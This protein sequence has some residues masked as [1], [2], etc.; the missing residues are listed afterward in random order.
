MVEAKGCF[1]CSRWVKS[2]VQAPW[3]C[4]TY[5]TTTVHGE[6]AARTEPMEWAAKAVEPCQ[7]W[8]THVSTDR[9]NNPFNGCLSNP[10]P[11]RVSCLIPAANSSTCLYQFS[12]PA[13]VSA[14]Q[15]PFW[16]LQ[17]TPC[18]STSCPLLTNTSAWTWWQQRWWPRFY[19]ILPTVVSHLLI[20]TTLWLRQ[21]C[22]FC[23]YE[24]CSWKY[25]CKTFTPCTFF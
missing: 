23:Y 16:Q 7:G 4:F 6:N 8:S 12:A 22:Q 24:V 17:A 14:I 10:T 15:Q 9:R 25:F 11:H 18:S 21:L 13:N 19:K 1:V 5:S 20:H 2:Q 3:N